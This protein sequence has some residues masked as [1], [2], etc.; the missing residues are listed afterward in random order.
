MSAT[1]TNTR[2]TH[3]LLAGTAP[4]TLWTL[5]ELAWVLSR[6]LALYGLF[7]VFLIHAQ[8]TPGALPLTGTALVAGG[9]YAL[10][11]SYRRARRAAMFRTPGGLAPEGAGVRPRRDLPSWAGSVLGHG[12]GIIT[13]VVLAGSGAGRTP[14]LYPGPPT[15]VAQ[16][17]LGL[18]LAVAATNVV[19][20]A[21]RAAWRGG[22]ARSWAAAATSVIALC[23]DAMMLLVVGFVAEPATVQAVLYYAP[24]LILVV[25]AIWGIVAAVAAQLA[26][27]PTVEGP[28]APATAILTWWRGTAT[29]DDRRRYGIW[30]D[31]AL[32]AAPLTI[33]ALA[34]IA[35]ATT[36]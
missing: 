5:G 19:V 36:H 16:V 26:K 30:I 11:L 34:L 35:V 14:Y 23:G 28:S 10:L 25:L 18:V 20:Q 17:F 8:H 2:H 32:V 31:R 21:A 12:L 15:T 33:A 27:Q 24:P 29:L 1:H 13:V 22:R 7:L 6:P 9:A 4:A 3:P